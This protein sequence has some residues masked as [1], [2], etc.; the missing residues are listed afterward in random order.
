MKLDG[1]HQLLAYAN[2]ENLLG[3]NRHTIKRKVG[4]ENECTET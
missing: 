1:T 4:T 2:D 3:Y